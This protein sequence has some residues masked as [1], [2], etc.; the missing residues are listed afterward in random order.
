MITLGHCGDIA[1]NKKVA[2]ADPCSC[3]TINVTLELVS[4]DTAQGGYYLAPHIYGYVFSEEEGVED[5]ISTAVAFVIYNGGGA[6]V[7][8]CQAHSWGWECFGYCGWDNNPY[9]YGGGNGG[10]LGYCPR[11]GNVTHYDEC[12]MDDYCGGIFLSLDCTFPCYSDT[13]INSEHKNGRSTFT[14]A[15]NKKYHMSW[16]ATGYWAKVS[17]SNGYV[18]RSLCHDAAKYSWKI[19]RGTGDDLDKEGANPDVIAEGEGTTRNYS[20]DNANIPTDFSDINLLEKVSF[21]TPKV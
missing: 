18:S 9:G 3:G 10:D 16:Y 15:R 17:H 2:E 12:C 20:Y 5:S 21:I 14:L 19:M 6:N 4:E 13:P 7:D 11:T 8:R 1:P